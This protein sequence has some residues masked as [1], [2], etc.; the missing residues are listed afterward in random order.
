MDAV[1]DRDYLLY[2]I[3]GALHVT[4]KNETWLLPP[5]FAAWLPANTPFR[6][7]FTKQVTV[8]SVLVQPGFCPAMPNA[9]QAFQMSVLTRHMIRYCK[10][11]GPD[12]PHPPDAEGFFLSLLNACARLAGTSVDVKRPH[13]A[14]PSLLK[15]I[16]LT[17]AR[18]AEKV[19]AAEIARAAHL[20]ERTLQ[21]R[22]A[23][24]V[25]LTW[26]ETLTRLRMI[27][28]IEL[29]SLDELSVIEIAAESG[30]NSLSAFN[31]AFLRFAGSTPTEFKAGLQD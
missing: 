19:T 21:R 14:D 29:L 3:R 15:A 30:F 9:A 13:A 28:A 26:S 16:D 1:F 6:A 23:S 27:R 4:V 24:E 12:V 22:F 11:W 2:A 5:S 31:R 8:C 18:L 10:D 25:G 17:E 7:E 20:S